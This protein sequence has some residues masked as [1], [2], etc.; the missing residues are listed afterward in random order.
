[1]NYTH[2]S[3]AHSD[4]KRSDAAAYDEWFR[5]RVQASQDDPRPSVP[6]DEVKARFAKRRAA[7]RVY[8]AK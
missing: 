7:L 1:M 6:N 8:A 3:P 2:Q 4:P 5:S